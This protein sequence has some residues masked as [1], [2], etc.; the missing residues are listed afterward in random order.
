[1]NGIVVVLWLRRLPLIKIFTTKEK[2]GT[3]ERISDGSPGPGT[4]PVTVIAKGM[5]KPETDITRF[6]NMPIQTEHGAVSSCFI[7][8][9][10]FSVT[11]TQI[12]LPVNLS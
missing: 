6:L 2:T 4:D 10:P 8:P 12:M 11:S 9:V 7:W 1:M 3:V 5:F